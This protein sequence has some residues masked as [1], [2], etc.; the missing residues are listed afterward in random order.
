MLRVVS[1]ERL[2]I[3]MASFNEITDQEKR[4]YRLDWFQWS[5]DTFFLLIPRPWIVSEEGRR[6]VESMR[7]IIQSRNDLLIF[8][9][10]QMSDIQ[11]MSEYDLWLRTFWWEK[12]GGIYFRVRIQRRSYFQR[13]WSWKIRFRQNFFHASY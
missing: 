10:F 5:F 9:R 13:S 3:L 8:E 1:Q 2:A 4:C 12:C 6:S 11:Y 7:C